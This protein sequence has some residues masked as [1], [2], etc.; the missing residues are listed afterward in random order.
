MIGLNGLKS[1]RSFF[2]GR[3]NELDSGPAINF[4][5]GLGLGP[6]GININQR[7]CADSVIRRPFMDCINF[8]KHS[9]P[10]WHRSRRILMPFL[11]FTE[12]ADTAPF[13]RSLYAG[14]T[15]EYSFLA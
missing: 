5:T 10:F 7:I 13:Q 15:N 11:P 3:F 12:S 4:Q 9:R 8:Y 6:S 2:S 14:Y 1:K